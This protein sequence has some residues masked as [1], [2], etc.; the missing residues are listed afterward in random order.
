MPAQY[1]FPAKSKEEKTIPFTPL[2]ILNDNVDGVQYY[3][4]KAYGKP[5]KI[6][7]YEIFSQYTDW[8]DF[9][10]MLLAIPAGIAVG[11]DLAAKEAKQMTYLINEGVNASMKSM[12]ESEMGGKYKKD[13]GNQKKLRE[14][15][16][17]LIYPGIITKEQWDIAFGPDADLA[18]NTVIT[19][20]APMKREFFMDETDDLRFRYNPT[21]TNWKTRLDGMVGGAFG[22][23]EIRA[24]LGAYYPVF[25]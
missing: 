22:P 7:R 13:M 6:D 1:V 25:A 3:V 19:Q 11:V 8:H 15:T 23:G 18:R 24:R 9:F 16:L 2:N 5:E 4:D 17:N 10:M 12:T 14:G 20:A 21:M